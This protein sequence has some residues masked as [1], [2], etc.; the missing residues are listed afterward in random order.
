MLCGHILILAKFQSRWITFNLL[1]CTVTQ[2][3]IICLQMSTRWTHLWVEDFVVPQ[4]NFARLFPANW[5]N[6]PE[7]RNVLPMKTLIACMYY[8]FTLNP[9]SMICMG[10]GILILCKYAVSDRWLD[11]TGWWK[12]DTDHFDIFY[13]TSIYCSGHIFV[14]A[15]IFVTVICCV[16]I[17]CYCHC[18]VDSF[19]KWGHQME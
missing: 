15:V 6:A 10:W 8:D 1:I 9:E 13:T 4:L 14:I 19:Y 5:M 12:V 2:V 3:L 18:L 11:R 7:G 17:N 16:F